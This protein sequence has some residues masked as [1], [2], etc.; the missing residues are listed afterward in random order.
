MTES[1]KVVHFASAN[2]C[3]VG[4]DIV[5]SWSDGEPGSAPDGMKVFKMTWDEVVEL[6]LERGIDLAD[7][8][9]ATMASVSAAFSA[10]SEGS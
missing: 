2:A 7:D 9:V 10:D 6:V 8:A 3:A 4:L 5:V 1:K